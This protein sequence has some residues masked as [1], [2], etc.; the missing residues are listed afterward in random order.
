[1]LGVGLSSLLAL[2]LV[3]GTCRQGLYICPALESF[4]EDTTHF[5]LQRNSFTR[6][7]VLFTLNS[8]Q[9]LKLPLVTSQTGARWVGWPQHKRGARVRAG[10]VKY[11]GTSP[12]K[13][14]VPR[15]RGVASG[16]RLRAWV[17]RAPWQA[18]A[19]RHQ[20]SLFQISLASRTPKD[21]GLCHVLEQVYSVLRQGS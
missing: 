11:G 12:P 2:P 15:P 18:A 6:L 7:L 3:N 5:A 20:A 1:M 21:Q 14:D 13:D 10:F 4:S 9:G 8:D 16:T 19:L 17:R